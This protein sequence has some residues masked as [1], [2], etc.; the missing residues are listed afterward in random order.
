MVIECKG[1]NRVFFKKEVLA[2]Y[3]HCFRYESKWEPIFGSV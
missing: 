2:V 3:V 1:R